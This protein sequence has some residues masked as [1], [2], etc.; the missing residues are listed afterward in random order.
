MSAL[1][2]G[3]EEATH[4][5]RQ[6]GTEVEEDAGMYN[7]CSLCSERMQHP[8]KAR[9]MLGGG[10]VTNL[11]ET[12]NPSLSPACLGFPRRAAPLQERVRRARGR[13]E[14]RV[15]AGVARRRNLI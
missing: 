3:G 11:V 8:S 9:E 2:T 13:A 4:A 10:D 7:T 15:A 14:G 5:W 12:A 6:L 1:D